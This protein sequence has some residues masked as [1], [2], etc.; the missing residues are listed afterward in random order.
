MPVIL[1]KS[2]KSA[3]LVCDNDGCQNKSKSYSTRTAAPELDACEQAHEQE[4]WAYN[5]GFYA[6]MLGHTV[7]YPKCIGK[8]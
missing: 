8:S 6:M 7:Y 5:I 3:V 4:G 1:N 2:K